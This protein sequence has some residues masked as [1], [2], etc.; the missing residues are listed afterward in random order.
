VHIPAM[1]RKSRSRTLDVS[2]MADR[3]PRWE[4]QLTCDG[5][6]I[7]NGFE[8][9]RIQARFEGYNAMFQLLAAGWNP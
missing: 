3:P 9:G 6:L 2:V 5:E 8:N 4:W 1:V 7:A